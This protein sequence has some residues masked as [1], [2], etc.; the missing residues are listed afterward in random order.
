[1]YNFILFCIIRFS[2]RGQDECC[3]R[4]QWL[5]LSCQWELFI[6]MCVC[7]CGQLS[8][9][10]FFCSSFNIL[11]F[12]TFWIFL[13]KSSDLSM[14]NPH[15][16]LNPQNPQIHG[17]ILRFSEDFYCEIHRFHWQSSDLAQRIYFIKSSSRS[18]E[19]ISFCLE[20]SV[21]QSIVR[22]PFTQS[23]LLVPLSIQIGVSESWIFQNTDL[24]LTQITDLSVLDHFLWFLFYSSHHE[25]LTFLG[26]NPQ[27][28]W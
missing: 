4:G 21:W 6:W 13:L 17:A 22:L 5:S 1:M 25:I 7:N 9:F 19:F 8:H 10:L 3:V 2:Q 14:V 12:Q 23:P 15:I 26:W 27:I 16:S 20:V 24:D 28:S 11:V 18:E